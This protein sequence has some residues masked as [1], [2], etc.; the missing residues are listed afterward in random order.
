[1]KLWSDLIKC[2]KREVAMRKHVYPKQIVNGTM[3]AD[4]CRHEI[5]CMEE[6]VNTLEFWSKRQQ[7]NLPLTEK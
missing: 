2:A 5:K 7:S 1:M 3:T 6:I 4:E